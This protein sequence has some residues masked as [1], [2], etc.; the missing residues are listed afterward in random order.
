MAFH[1]GHHKEYGFVPE[2]G[3]IASCP[4]IFS[5][6]YSFFSKRRITAEASAFGDFSQVRH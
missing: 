2:S 4:L 5:S 1:S 6:V 3:L